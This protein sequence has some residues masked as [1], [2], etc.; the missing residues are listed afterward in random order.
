MATR[1]LATLMLLTT[2]ASFAPG[3]ALAAGSPVLPSPPAVED[4]EARGLI[5]ELYGIVRDILAGAE[6]A[7]DRLAAFIDR[8]FTRIR[9][10]LATIRT[11]SQTATC[12]DP[13]CRTYG[14]G[15]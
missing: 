12:H 8:L 11:E 3:P 5:Q 9:E 10:G 15:S 14:S 7:V 2:L 13:D 6:G 1:I 4:P